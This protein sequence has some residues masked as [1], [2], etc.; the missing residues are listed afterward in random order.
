MGA[1]CGAPAVDAMEAADPGAVSGMPFRSALLDNIMLLSDSY[2]TSHWRQYP[3]NTTEVYSYFE[4]R[5]GKFDEICFFGLQYFMKRYLQG[6][7]VTAEKINAAERIVNA[8]MGLGEMK[9]FNREGWE[10]ILQKHGGKLP[11][12]IK[13]VP[14]GMVV[15][16]KNVLM[17]VVNTDPKCFWLTNYLETLLVQVW[18]PMTVAT[19]SRAQKKVIMDAMMK[20][21]T[22]LKAMPN[23]LPAPAKLITVGF[24]LNDFGCRGVSSMETAC[25]GG[26]AHL[27][28]FCGSDT[29]PGLCMAVDYY[30]LPLA[31]VQGTSVPAAEHSTITSWTK[32]GEKDAFKNMLTQYPEGIVAVVSDS[33]DIYNACDQLWGNELKDLIASRAPPTGRLVVRPDSGDPKTIVVDVLERLAK[34]FPVTTNAAG[35]KVLPPYLRVIQGDGISYESLQEIL[36]NMAAKH[37]AAENVLFG[38]GGALLQKMDR[39]TQKCAFKCCEAVVDGKPR[40]VFKDPITDQGK[41]SKQGRLKLVRR[42]GKITTLTD[43]Q[44][45]EKEDLLVEVFRN[46]Q[47]TKTWTF[48]DVRAQSE[49]GLPVAIFD[50]TSD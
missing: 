17:T 49:V 20:T 15:P 36:S 13:A 27:V 35:Y 44:G 6:Q 48:A 26:A 16:V 46:G 43:G 41:K 5:G 11:I 31:S 34:H 22:D 14:E 30:N 8:H 24:Q 2:K 12:V 28:N 42:E 4:S 10:Y 1:V 9:H 21:G 38:S 3:P 32:A 7:V 29:M 25:I 40:P 23:K 18:Y 33:Y 50:V 19:Q 39:D 47:I 37:W 45:D